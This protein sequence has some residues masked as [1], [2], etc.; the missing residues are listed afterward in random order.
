MSYYELSEEHKN[1]SN[2]ELLKYIDDSIIE[3]KELSENREDLVSFERELSNNFRNVVNDI[4][5]KRYIIKC[6]DSRYF[7][8]IPFEAISDDNVAHAIIDK[9]TEETYKI[10][11]TVNEIG[12]VIK[13]NTKKL[14]PV[15]DKM[16]PVIKDQVLYFVRD[17]KEKYP[18]KFDSEKMKRDIL[19]NDIEFISSLYRAVRNR[20]YNTVSDMFKDENITLYR[21]VALI[22]R[23]RDMNVISY[24]QCPFEDFI[25]CAISRLYNGL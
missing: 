13:N 2:E 7:G 18:K 9:Y 10:V 3:Y 25:H 15:V 16:I 4:N 17:M 6:R 19:M 22:S 20:I 12:N 14:A 21:R 23:L 11:G 24:N 5:S 1:M 8:D